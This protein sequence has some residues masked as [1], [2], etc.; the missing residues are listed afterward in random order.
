MF[1]SQSD[2]CILIYPY[3]DIAFVFA[4]KFEEPT[5]GISVIG[6]MLD[7]IIM[8][9][10]PGKLITKKKINCFFSGKVLHIFRRFTLQ[11][12]QEEKIVRSLKHSK[13]T[14]MWLSSFIYR[15]YQLPI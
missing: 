1:C 12:C 13:M 8:S 3:L 9:L 14:K 6:L 11:V 5:I 2:N 10:I 4:A 15:R 7:T